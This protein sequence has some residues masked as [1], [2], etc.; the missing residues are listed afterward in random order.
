[1][2]QT[3]KTRISIPH[4]MLGDENAKLRQA[5]LVKRCLIVVSSP[6]MQ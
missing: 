3:L 6:S 4:G 2:L 1:M 5:Y